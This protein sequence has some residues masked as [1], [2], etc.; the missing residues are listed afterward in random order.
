[1]NTTTSLPLDQALDAYWRMAQAEQRWDA[2]RSRLRH[3]R[4]SPGQ[5]SGE[6]VCCGRVLPATEKYPPGTR[7]A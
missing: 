5:P 4:T 6:D 1:M 2:L 7:A 3:G